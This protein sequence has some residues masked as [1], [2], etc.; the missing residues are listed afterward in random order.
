MHVEWS[1]SSATAPC[2]TDFLMPL[3]ASSAVWPGFDVGHGS[4]F[5]NMTQSTLVKFF[6]M[7]DTVTLTWAL[8][9]EDVLF[10]HSL[11]SQENA[12]DWV[13]QANFAVGNGGQ[14]L[15]AYSAR[16]NFPPDNSQSLLERMLDWKMWRTVWVVQAGVAGLSLMLNAKA[17]RRHYLTLRSLR[18]TSDT[19][20]TGQAWLELKLEGR[21]TKSMRWIAFGI[22]QNIANIWS[23]LQMALPDNLV[24]NYSE[25]DWVFS[26]AIFLTLF[27]STQYLEFFPKYYVLISTVGEGLPSVLRFIVGCMPLYIAYTALGTILFGRYC[28]L[29]GSIGMS[30]ITLFSVLNGDS[31]LDV[32]NC[33]YTT[34]YGSLM[35]TTSQIYLFLFVC[36]YIYCAI[37]VF[38]TIM[39][40]AF[41]RV[42]ISAAAKRRD[43]KELA[44]LP[45]TADEQE[46]MRESIYDDMVCLSNFSS[47]R[48]LAEHRQTA[49]FDHP[50]IDIQEPDLSAAAAGPFFGEKSN[51]PTSDSGPLA[52]LTLQRQALSRTRAVVATALAQLDSELAALDDRVSM[53]QQQQQQQQQQQKQQHVDLASPTNDP[54]PSLS[55]LPDRTSENAASNI[56]GEMGYEIELQ[57]MKTNGND[58]ISIYNSL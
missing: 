17:V 53:V 43:R 26:V 9:D 7:V 10:L 12:V 41:S 50:P 5:F 4:S 27:N 11:H 21:K 36:V 57:D 1:D 39:S 34:Q 37:S 58:T 46:S 20:A 35:A 14:M 6:D 49:V 42:H 51:S 30:A 33:I 28:E 2:G 55:L 15:V 52:L 24:N 31:M 25:T 44:V 18:S 8:R 32:F 3:N 16:T 56:A 29:F 38:I 40:D 23:A 54:A 47:S 48:R 22:A 19:Q 13:L 45:S